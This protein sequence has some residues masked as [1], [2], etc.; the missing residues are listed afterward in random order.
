MFG[1]INNLG[2][3]GQDQKTDVFGKFLTASN[4][5]LWREKWTL[6]CIPSQHLH[7]PKIF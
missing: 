7:F 2:K 4:K 3:I 1:K 5:H 6:G